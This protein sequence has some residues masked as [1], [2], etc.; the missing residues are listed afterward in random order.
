MNRLAQTLRQAT[1]PALVGAALMLTACGSSTATTT[2]RTTSAYSSAPPT[3]AP[4]NLLELNAASQGVLEATS[5][6]TLE[7][8]QARTQ[9][10]LIKLDQMP[11]NWS[12]NY[13]ILNAYKQQHS[14]TCYADPLLQDAQLSYAG[15]VFDE[16]GGEVYPE[17]GG[18]APE[19]VE[20]IG[21][22]TWPALA[23]GLFKSN[24]DNCTTF[25]QYTQAPF[26]TGVP[27]KGTMRRM[28]VPKYG[29][30]SV[31]YTAS[32]AEDGTPAPQG[33]IIARKGSYVVKV[34]LSGIQSVDKAL[35]EHL[36]SLAMTNLP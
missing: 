33:I 24:L 5:G 25:T 8:D 19:M 27:V 32:I 17:S 22:Y 36:M 12:R 28:S 7:A 34:D 13:S 6:E 2:T 11:S 9:S 20:V 29:A 23:F 26:G 1:L 31:G 4:T 10:L 16:D 30:E 35:L 21:T 14:A 18:H 15:I 3:S